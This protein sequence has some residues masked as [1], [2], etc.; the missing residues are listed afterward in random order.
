MNVWTFNWYKKSTLKAFRLYRAL[1]YTHPKNP[2]VKSMVARFE[3]KRYSL[4]HCTTHQRVQGSI[5]FMVLTAPTTTGLPM[6]LLWKICFSVSLASISA[7][8]KHALV[9]RRRAQAT[10]VLRH[11]LRRHKMHAAVDFWRTHT[12]GR[13]RLV[14]A[15]CGL[16]H[17]YL[18]FDAS[19]CMGPLAIGARMCCRCYAR[20]CSVI[21]S[22]DKRCL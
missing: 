20:A 11:R 10:R 8:H 5:S 1:L 6:I 7:L 4:P 19:R 13:R 3:Q 16:W 22:D 15:S 18:R 14:L 12:L 17:K 2:S 9:C 21:S